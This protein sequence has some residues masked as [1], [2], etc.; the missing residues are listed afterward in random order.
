MNNSEA[1][2]QLKRLLQIESSKI[3]KQ[4]HFLAPA[5]VDTVK[6][7]NVVIVKIRVEE[8]QTGSKLNKS[9]DLGLVEAPLMVNPSIST[10]IKKGD[11]GLLLCIDYFNKNIPKKNFYEGEQRNNDLNNAWFLPLGQDPKS[12]ETNEKTVKLDARDGKLILKNNQGDLKK[13]L[14][15]LVNLIQTCF[16]DVKGALRDS[17]ATPQDGGTALQ[18]SINAILATSQVQSKANEIKNKLDNLMEDSN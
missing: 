13:T 16:D 18:A 8:L 7:A 2:K 15:D 12:A 6:S 9:K 11:Q 1:S 17:K 14:Q 3:F 4:Q 5:I 10:N